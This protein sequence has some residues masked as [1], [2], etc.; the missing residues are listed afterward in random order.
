M[1][2]VTLG[3]ALMCLTG[4]LRWW[5][6]LIL[7]AG[8]A[9]VQWDNYRIAMAHRAGRLVT[10]DPEDLSLKSWPVI[11]LLIG[12][13]LLG[14]AVGARLLVDGAVVVARGAGL[15]ETVIGLTLVAVGTSAPELVTSV[16]AALRRQADVAL[17][18]VIGSCTLNILAILGP[19]ALIADL[20]VARQIL[21]FD[22]W[23]MV[24]TALLLAPYVVFGR[25][26]RRPDGLLFVGLYV[27]YVLWQLASGQTTP[28]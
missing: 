11:G 13:G 4:P 9:V 2:A 7:L 18:N 27:A 26:I 20:P 21:V 24:A 8:L 17:G 25:D 28:A 23:I 22:N 3:F 15:S 14:L 6:G 16:M 10:P 1:V 12:L 5:H 19:T